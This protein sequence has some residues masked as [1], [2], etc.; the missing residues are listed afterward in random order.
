MFGWAGSQSTSGQAI[1]PGHSV[2]AGPAA[3]SPRAGRR[4]RWNACGA[5]GHVRAATSNRLP[6]PRSS[7]GG[8]SYWRQLPRSVRWVT[9]PAYR[10]SLQSADQVW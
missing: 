5:A 2:V 9:T 3:R 7:S 8:G 6:R 1:Y 4:H 10:G